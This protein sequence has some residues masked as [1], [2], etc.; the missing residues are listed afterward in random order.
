MFYQYNHLGTPDYLK[1]ERGTD[2]SFP[3][4]L[5]QCFEIIVVRS[6]EMTVTVDQKP[7][8]LKEK[9]ALLIFPNQ[10]H[11]LESTKSEHILCIFSSRL[12]QAYASKVADKLPQNNKF[13]PDEYLVN[14]LA[15]LE[16]TSSSAEKKGI[17]YSLCGQFDKTAAYD[18]KQFKNEKLLFKIFLFVETSFSK[19]CSLSNLSKKT[20]YDYSY[21]SRYF[22]KATGISF[23]SYVTHF[24]LSHACYLMENTE[25]SILQC[26]YDSGFV[27]LRSF[28]RCFK[29]CL[30]TTPTQYLKN[31]KAR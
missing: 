19:D 24:R 5:H 3:S 18:K 25:Q 27:S 16:S 29:E 7:F 22:K 12:V 30:K 11:A 14:A 28:N 1:I 9:E 17:L 31:L 4:H 26:A 2:F 8:T 20:G 21:L 6:G 13:Q 23:N 10:I 15:D